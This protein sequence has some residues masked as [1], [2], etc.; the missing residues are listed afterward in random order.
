MNKKGVSLIL[1]L[2]YIFSGSAQD[3]QMNK[4][5]ETINDTLYVLENGA[6]YRVDKSQVVVKLRDSIK[7]LPQ[8]I[9]LLRTH[10][11]GYIDIEVPKDNNVIDYVEKLKSLGIFE[12]VDYISEVKTCFT[13]NDHSLVYNPS[14]QWYIDRINLWNAWD[15]T[16]GV[17]SIKIA[18][19]DSGVN[20][21]NPDLGY[22]DD[23]Y[24]NLDSNLEKNYLSDPYDQYR[25][26]HGTS[27]AG[28]I[29][30]K[31]NNG[32]GVAGV[33]GGNNSHGATV[34]SYRIIK[35]TTSPA[36]YV[37]DAIIDATDDGVKVINCSFD[38]NSSPCQVDAITYAI[39]HGV[40]IVCSTGNYN[41]SNITFP[42][43]DTRT[44]AVGA[45]NNYD[46]RWSESS[47]TGSN[48]GSGID[49]VAPGVDVFTTFTYTYGN[50][51]GTSVASPFVAGTVALMRSMNSSLSPSQIRDI[52]QKT[53][54]KISGYTYNSSGW[55]SEVGYGVL[56]AFAAVLGACNTSFLED[57][58]ICYGSSASFSLNNLPSG[59]SVQWSITDGYGP[60]TPTIQTSGNS[61]SI[62]NNLSMTFSGKLNAKVYDGT[63]L[64]AT[65]TKNLVLY[66]DFYGQY[67]SDNL[68]GTIDYTHIFYVKPGYN[69]TITSL[70]LVGATASYSNSG[71]TPSYFSLDP[72][73]WKLYF[74]MPTN[75]NGIPVII[76]VTDLCGNQF[77]LYAIPQS[78][79]YLNISYEGSN[80]NISLNENGNALRNPSIEQP[81][82]YEIRSATR[83]D[84]KASGKVYSSYTTISTA[85]WPK[86]IYIVKA[87]IG[88][89]DTTEKIIVR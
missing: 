85:G 2:A 71:T 12:S 45:I 89:E 35:G 32:E 55:N 73:L 79:Y 9:K 56:N 19:I 84:I 15:I 43:S 8:N 88:K 83:G 28:V 30:A 5:L 26:W 33:A 29:G 7:N 24:T 65:L 27:T 13:I 14:R 47:S 44:I 58:S 23:T 68:S 46:L 25:D 37:A 70:N 63:N 51:T 57:T 6:K 38:C 11:L 62:T 42:A 74:T 1:F 82:S 22:G 34:I 31:T 21:N 18:V 80:I 52:L 54:T 61:C 40:T 17:S 49:L 10:R 4:E 86:G 48:Y 66:S 59:L 16:T 53:A 75:N 64:I 60:T 81:W 20:W 41:N 87:T 50:E 76:N 78:S 3:I 39:N 69:T 67:T 72:T 77:Q 36:T